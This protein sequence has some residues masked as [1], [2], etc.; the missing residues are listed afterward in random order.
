[1]ELLSKMTLRLISLLVL[2]VHFSRSNI[3]LVLEL[4]YLSLIYILS[5]KGLS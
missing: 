3:S 1:M 4:V 5:S 2:I